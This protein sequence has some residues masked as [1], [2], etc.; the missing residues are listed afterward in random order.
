M[1]RLV[2]TSRRSE[3]WLKDNSVH[4]NFL[5]TIFKYTIMK[6]I[7]RQDKIVIVFLY[8]K[9]RNTAHHPTNICWVIN[10]VN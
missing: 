7:T 5:K 8:P 1:I 4:S 9:L 6:A 2:Y 3:T 10:Y